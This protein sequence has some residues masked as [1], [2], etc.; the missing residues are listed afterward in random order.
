M[1]REPRV[2][3]GVVLLKDDAIL[4]IQRKREPEA[5]CWSL[6]G[7]KVD[8]GEP[9][10]AAAARETAEELDVQAEGLTL[11]CVVDLI[12]QGDDTHWVSPVYLAK[13]FSGEPRLMEPHK[14]AA[15]GWFAL[16]ALPAP[17]A[18]SAA[19]AAQALRARS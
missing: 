18:S 6:P 8:W 9:S 16:D 14:H 7:G 10:M 12:G 11:L 2:G 3:C 17:L 4:L 19:V 5:G 13:A 1:S 15:F